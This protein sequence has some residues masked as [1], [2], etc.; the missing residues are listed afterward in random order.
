MTTIKQRLISLNFALLMLISLIQPAG[1]VDNEKP[2]TDAAH[3]YEQYVIVDGVEYDATENHSG[4]G[5][6]SYY[7]KYNNDLRI[8]LSDYSGGSIISNIDLDIDIGGT[9]LIEGTSY[10]IYTTGDLYFYVNTRN[11][12][13]G[14]LTVRGA[15]SYEAIHSDKTTH[16]GGNLTAIGNNRPAISSDEGIQLFRFWPMRTYVGDSAENAREGAYSDQTYVSFDK[17]PYTMTLHGNGGVDATNQTEK[18][19]VYTTGTAGYLFLYPYFKTF[20]NGEKQLIGWSD[21]ADNVDKTHAVDEEYQY[22]NNTYSADLYAV[23]EDTVHKAVVLKNYYGEYTQTG[24]H[25]GD[26][27]PIPIEK[28][29]TYTLP[30]QTCSG[31][32]FDGWLAEDGTTLYPAG[33]VITVD[34]TISFT[35]RFTPLT[36]KIDGQEY[37]ASQ[38][39]SGRGWDYCASSSNPIQLRI[40]NSY[41]GQ[42]IEI[43]S[44]ARIYLHKSMNGT[45]NVA[46]IIVHGNAEIESYVFNNRTDIP[47]VI[48]G[49][50]NAPAIIA[51][52][53]V[54]VSVYNSD[55]SNMKFVVKSGNSDIPAIQANNIKTSNKM[56]YA[57]TDAENVLP[58]TKY[59]GES[60]AEFIGASSF[61]VTL[62]GK[63]TIP[64]PLEYDDYTFVGWQKPDTRLLKPEY[65][66]WY[67]PGDIIDAGEGITLKSVELENNKTS[68]AIILDGQG[69]KTKSSS[70]YFVS[71]VSNFELKE[72][73][74]PSTA[75]TYE[76]KTLTGYN[77]AADGSGTAY[78]PNDKLPESTF[79]QRLY[80]QWKD[81][82]AGSTGGSGGG[83]SGGGGGGGAPATAANTISAPNISNGNVSLDKNTAKKGDTVTVT[84]TPDAAYQL[85]KLTVTDAKGNTIAVAKKGDNQYT[86]TMPDSKVTITP[87]FSKI[88]DTKPSK[89][90][91]D[92]VAS[93][94]WFADAVKYVADKGL[95]N[96][97]DD[98]QFSPNA[99]TTRGMLMTVLA[100]HAG[101]D[102]TGGAAWYEKGMNWAKA[103]GVS[104]GTNPNANITR[105]QL[106]TMM[107]RYAGSPKADGKLDSFS[108]AASVSTYAADAMQW[109]VAN[110]IVNGSNGKLNPQNNATR[111][112]VAAILMRFCEM[113]K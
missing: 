6:H 2:A 17:I 8:S 5:W 98:N 73:R 34:E 60:Y 4:T 12:Q 82:N 97:T 56:L 24:H 113:S 19:I 77:T 44:D 108:D 65:Q 36:L 38:D 43:P 49:G 14:H 18:Q 96:G 68:R 50:E 87:T 62:Q 66:E 104:D 37:D 23:W 25:F 91:F 20:S 7:D 39:H 99:S 40:E 42:P 33:T 31:C 45:T 58:V 102:T 106:V 52:R 1:A 13:D 41:S 70:N 72:Y 109:A 111:A 105:E 78:Q 92:D 75:F 90:G 57:G 76:G 46:P 71:I 74:L 112:E 88:E 27:L 86:F 26:T 100:R 64:G 107:Y 94:D 9:S 59:S 55:N 48:T 16:V 93:S 81:T 30:D 22:A 103:K 89:N 63:T 110:G 47:V 15:G 61:K 95:M 21:S 80:A 3:Q 83:A 79:I 54:V 29:M 85:D 53:N 35:A 10:G 51:D 101:E 69:G 32:R 28:G 11:G 67:M 84:V